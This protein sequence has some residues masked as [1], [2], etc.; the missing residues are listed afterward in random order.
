MS[1]ASLTFD[2]PTGTANTPLVLR[3]KR[4]WVSSDSW[5]NVASGVIALA[6]HAVVL[7]VA[8]LLPAGDG[9]ERP[10]LRAEETPSSVTIP[11]EVFEDGAAEDAPAA[12]PPPPR[13][14]PMSPAMAA[15]IATIARVQQ[16]IATTAAAVA[17]ARAQA[18][19]PVDLS[20][21][22]DVRGAVTAGIVSPAGM[23]A[24][25]GAGGGGGAPGGGAQGVA[26]VP[27]AGGQA[28]S[29]PSLAQPARP[30]GSNWDCPWPAE[31]QAAAIYAQNVT[32]RVVV[33]A[34]GSVASASAQ[35]DPGFGFA[36]AAEACA[37]RE[38]FSPARDD[39]GQPV[40]ATTPA[41][42]VRFRR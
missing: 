17:T 34:D 27:G 3:Q 24:L 6:L 40:R 21:L 35:N 8:G 7:W 5:R 22:T 1:D 9:G 14:A 16:A 10:A 25:V 23:G 20:H 19:A 37:R 31:A 29:R 39:S 30:T 36:A 13:A 42:R 15:R 4:A 33:N 12:A 28:P 18:S 11:L 32:V 26:G 41:M 38:S 2:P